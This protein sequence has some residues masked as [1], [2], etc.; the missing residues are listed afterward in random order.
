[1]SKELIEQLYDA[2]LSLPGEH[3][4]INGHPANLNVCVEAADRI[5]E[6]EAEVAAL[7]YAAQKEAVRMK[8]MEERQ[9]PNPHRGKGVPGISGNLTWGHSRAQSRALFRTKITGE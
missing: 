9:N 7:R 5:A 2:S 1:M 8:D 3:K 4:D 6:L